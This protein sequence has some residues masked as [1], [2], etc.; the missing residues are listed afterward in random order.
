M[1]Q[2]GEVSFTRKGLVREGIGGLERRINLEGVR[3]ERKVRVG[4]D[5]TGEE[6]QSKEGVRD[7]RKVRV[8]IGLE[9]RGRLEQGGVQRVEEG[10]NRE[11]LEQ[12]G[13]QRGEEGQR[14][15]EVE[16]Q[17]QVIEKERNMLEGV[18][19]NLWE[20]KQM[21]MKM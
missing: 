2:R 19:M 6:G 7:E 13:R 4:R 14:V 11:G 15:C 9:R 12:G 8:G 1:V 18:E 20:G 5:Q 21:R 17:R 16:D 10:Q 3:E